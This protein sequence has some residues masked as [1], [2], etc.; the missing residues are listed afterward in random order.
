MKPSPGNFLKI[1]EERFTWERKCRA[2]EALGE[3]VNRHPGS[4]G[5]ERGLLQ[6]PLVSRKAE[7][8]AEQ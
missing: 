3:N 5:L 8:E 6:A 4:S 2:A 7:G 1:V